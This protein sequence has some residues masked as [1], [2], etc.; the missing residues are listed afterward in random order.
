MNHTL[1]DQQIDTI[2]NEHLNQ[3]AW[4]FQLGVSSK[5]DLKHAD[6]DFSF[7][8]YDRGKEL[9]EQYKPL[10]KIILCDKER[11]TIKL[12]IDE[13]LLGNVRELV[14]FI[15]LELTNTHNLAV[16]I[17]IPLVAIVIKYSLHN[18]CGNI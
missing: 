8:F 6:N 12:T 5:E 11:K 14:V 18:F 13:G 10:L 4:L 3:D 9:W 2:L 15:Y 16:G 1:T 7:P 17:A